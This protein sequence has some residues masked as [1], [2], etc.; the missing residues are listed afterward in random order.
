MAPS[1]KRCSAQV[2]LVDS[3]PTLKLFHFGSPHEKK[4]R[5]KKKKENPS[6][7]TLDSNTPV[8]GK[9]EGSRSSMHS[10]VLHAE[11]LFKTGASRLAIDDPKSS[12]AEKDPTSRLVALSTENS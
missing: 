10:H 4:R 7:L 8:V 11:A 2:S 9:R 12:E 6:N 1:L 5:N 3:L